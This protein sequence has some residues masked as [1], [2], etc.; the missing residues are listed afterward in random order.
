MKALS[1]F[2]GI[3]GLDLAAEWAGIETIA[4]C[5]R[6]PY[7]QKVLKRHWPDVPCFDD[8]KTLKGVDVGAVDII[9]GSYP[10]QGFS[11][12]GKRGGKDD[13]RYL[14]PEMLRL[15]RELRP[16]FVVGENV[17]GYVS[18][19]LD[20]VLA[21]LGAEDY[22]ARAFVFPAAAVGANHKRDR[23]FIVANANSQ[24]R[25]ERPGLREGGETGERW[26]RSFND[27]GAF[28][29]K[30]PLGPGVGGGLDG[31]SAELDGSGVSARTRAGVKNRAARLK[32]LGNTCVP[33]QAYP[34]MKAIADIHAGR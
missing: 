1:L 28:G 16:Y 14:W 21:D 34:I 31:I 33:Q 13:P 3:G 4:F 20:D 25:Q 9:F 18:L 27:G 12:A 29:G 2:S 26:R 22:Q 11:L 15:V 8:V 23:V 24:P 17:A 19:G 30:R 32:A 7:C 5:E 6:D 10:C